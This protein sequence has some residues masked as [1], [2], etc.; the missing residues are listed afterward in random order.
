M[1]KSDAL[2]LLIKNMTAAEKG[3]FKKSTQQCG[4]APDRHYVQLFDAI[5]RQTTYDEVA[6][7]TQFAAGRS[8]SYFATLKRYLYNA[9]LKSLRRFEEENDLENQVSALFQEAKLLVRR[10]LPE[11]G[12]K[13]IRKAKK[14][15]YR[16][17]HFSM[18]IDIL[19]L[20]NNT[21][22]FFLMDAKADEK[23][24]INTE[25]KRLLAQLNLERFYFDVY[26]RL[27][28]YSRK[29]RT[30]RTAS[31]TQRLQTMLN[32][33]RCQDE[34]LAQSLRARVL[35]FGLHYTWQMLQG[36]YAQAYAYSR[37]AIEVWEMATPLLQR[38]RFRDYVASLVN[39]INR[40]YQL[41]KTS[42]MQRWIERFEQ[43]QAPSADYA[44]F[45]QIQLSKLKLSYFELSNDF[46]S[47]DAEALRIE[48][49]LKK[50]DSRI[51][52]TEQRLL[53]YNLTNQY[54]VCGWPDRALDYCTMLLQLPP[55]EVQQ[56]LQR[57]A[58]FL[59]LLLHYE[60]RHETL[61]LQTWRNVRNA[62]QKQGKYHRYETLFLQM[63]Q[64]LAKAMHQY[65][66]RD[67]F[68][69]YLKRFE[70]LQTDKF[71]K[72]AFEFLD[73]T[74]WLRAQLKRTSMEDILRRG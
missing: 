54:L 74:T 3:Y 24:A 40:C 28:L 17:E 33:A 65:G 73:I 70:A 62:L 71:E 51:D 35:L 22:G 9:I 64:Q 56:D 66:K 59:H 63:M 29:E 19:H 8:A 6:L 42:E 44:T 25:I 13:R 46:S 61:L 16:I 2:F 27:F 45:L 1:A 26:D 34:S 52:M 21:I 69:I 18:L 55:T 49:L 36:N 60:M 30:L 57:F 11:Q 14:L 12:M 7:E 31:Q 38:A 72:R 41:G 37:K 15:A 10:G 20:E 43:L 67:L 48:T 5:E 50:D 23:S 32:D 53:L 39:H 4:G 47:L 68:A 58:R